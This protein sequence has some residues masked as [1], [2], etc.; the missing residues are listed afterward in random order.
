MFFN[1]SIP[2]I[3]T[4]VLSVSSLFAE[5]NLFE[6]GAPMLPEDCM[7]KAFTY[8]KGKKEIVPAGEDNQNQAIRI[9]V[10]GGAENTWAV[11]L[12][13]PCAVGISKGDAI[14]IRMKARAVAS[15]KE[16]AMGL[17]SFGPQRNKD[18]WEKPVF[19]HMPIPKDWTDIECGGI[20]NVDIPKEELGLYF[21]LSYCAQTLEF[22]EIQ[23]VNLGQGF[24]ESK[25][26]RPKVSYGGREPDAPWRKE[27]DARIEK[28]RKADI[29][30]KI[31][32]KDGSPVSDAS[33][34]VR[35]QRHA[36]PWG[37]CIASPL[38]CQKK[39]ANRSDAD[40]AK[41]REWLLK[42]FNCAVIE[43]NLKPYC[44]YNPDARA[45]GLESVKW[46]NEH[47]LKVRGHTAVWPAEEYFAPAWKKLVGYDDKRKSRTKEELLAEVSEDDRQQ[48]GRLVKQHV[49][50]V[51]GA[52]KGMCFQWDVVNEPFSCHALM[53]LLGD[54]VMIE[55]FKTAKSADP[56]TQLFINDYGIVTDG[57]HAAHYMNTIKFLLD[58]GAPLEGIGEQG[59]YGQQPP[60]IQ[61]VLDTYDMLGT[62][63]LPV[64]CTEFD[65]NTKDEKLQ[66][67]FT[68]DYM[69][70]LFSNPSC[71]GFLMWGFWEGSHW[72]PEAAMLKKDWNPKPN[73]KAYQDLVFDKWWTDV[74]GKTDADGIFRTRG[75]LGEYEIK[76]SKDTKA[77]SHQTSVGKGGL[78]VSFTSEKIKR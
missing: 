54:E 58:G 40:V 70:A 74:E 28:L 25:L 59:H 35:M 45:Q 52:T 44:W 24:D 1:K 60:D 27:A 37:T 57:A 41:Y 17:I 66:A 69:T 32:D 73:L 71:A 65:V 31:T 75:F 3:F 46:L 30:I 33:V 26:P 77:W 42:L 15:S 22:S 14:L 34:H 21:H 48:L 62:F 13:I 8:G 36:F 76:A 20:S 47:G 78:K 2:A 53:D 64:V 16:T 55:W 7:E 72:I 39:P 61:K 12:I 50:D 67:D 5:E 56:T 29:I 51:V 68:R 19:I 18:P 38:L 63:K 10:P 43:N 6:K 11:Q 4:V 49:A 23:M 9:E